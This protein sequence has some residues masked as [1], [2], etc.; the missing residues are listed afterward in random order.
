[1]AVLKAPHTTHR[2]ESGVLDLALFFSRSA[3]SSQSLPHSISDWQCLQVGFIS[4]SLS[5]DELFPTLSP[6]RNSPTAHFVRTWAKNPVSTRGFLLWESA[7]QGVRGISRGLDR[8][9]WRI[10]GQLYPRPGKGIATIA[11]KKR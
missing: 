11:L 7:F 9:L 6:S 10:F 8:R 2:R 3:Q 5:L 1:M 4:V